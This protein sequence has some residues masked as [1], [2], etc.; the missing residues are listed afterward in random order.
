M[1]CTTF[2]NNFTGEQKSFSRRPRTAAEPE[3]R[4]CRGHLPPMRRGV[5]TLLLSKHN[6][7]SR[8]I[9][10][11]PLHRF[12]SNLLF[13]KPSPSHIVKLFN[14]KY[15]AFSNIQ[16]DKRM[17]ALTLSFIVWYV[18]RHS[19]GTTNL[20]PLLPPCNLFSFVN[21]FPSNVLF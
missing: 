10:P 6:L 11:R 15:S 21:I 13:Q 3:G 2:I 16:S 12:P 18:Q 19:K 20:G 4:G 7:G 8:I 14:T 9:I 5:Y 17:S 1:Q